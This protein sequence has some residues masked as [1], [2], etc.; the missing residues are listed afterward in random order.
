VFSGGVLIA[1]GCGIGLGLAVGLVA[2]GVLLVAYCLLLAD[3]D[4]GKT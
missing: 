4:G 3:V 1:A 2:G